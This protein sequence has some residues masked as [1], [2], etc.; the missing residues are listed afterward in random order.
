M[1]GAIGVM[2]MGDRKE[3]EGEDVN[4]PTWLRYSFITINRI[5]FPIVAFLMMWYVCQ[6]S[7]GKVV[8]SVEQNTLVLLEVRDTLSRIAP[9][10]TIP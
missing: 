8:A 9:S 3:D 1:D 2:R 6:V 5:G 7:I 4:I 10:R